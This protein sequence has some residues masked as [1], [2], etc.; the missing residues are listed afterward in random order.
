[1]KDHEKRKKKKDHAVIY[2]LLSKC[3]KKYIYIY[4][5]IYI[6]THT[7]EKTQK[8]KENYLKSYHI[9]TITICFFLLN[10]YFLIFLLII[11]WPAI[12]YKVYE[13]TSFLHLKNEDNLCLL[14]LRGKWDLGR[15][16]S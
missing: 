3:K 8:Y 10:F 5:Y 6:H 16:D 15:G 1:M 11:S 12:N 13:L 7:L 2:K 4:I 9:N 14:R